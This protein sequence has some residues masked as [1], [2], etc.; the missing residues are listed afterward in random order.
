M[1]AVIRPGSPLR[2]R[3]SAPVRLELSGAD[4]DTNRPVTLSAGIEL[5]YE[6]EE[7]AAYELMGHMFSTR[8][9]FRVASGERRGQQLSYLNTFYEAEPVWP[10]V[11]ELFPPRGLEPINGAWP[12]PADDRLPAGEGQERWVA[13]LMSDGLEPEA[14][15]A[16]NAHKIGA[17]SQGLHRFA[18]PVTDAWVTEVSRIL[19]S[20]DGVELARQRHPELAGDPTE[21]L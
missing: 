5:A 8:Y 11:Q 9:W 4:R 7:D 15:V 13:A 21:D 12:P 14:W 20:D 16:A 18:D 17:W 6:G 1:T 10:A 2:W 3:T 19:D